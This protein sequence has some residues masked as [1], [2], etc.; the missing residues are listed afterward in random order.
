[1][2]VSHYK[3]TPPGIMA[4][5]DLFAKNKLSYLLF[6][7]D[8]IFEGQN[9]NLDILFETNEDYAHAGKILQEQGF[10]IRLSEKVERYKTM[11]TGFVRQEMY[12]IHLHREIAWHGMIA[13]DKK[14]V[15]QHKKIITPHIII[16]GLEDS[17]LIHAAHVLFENFRITEKE[18]VYL[19]K[20]GCADKAYLRDQISKHHWKDGFQKVIQNKVSI[21]AIAATWS[22]KLLNEPGTMVY[23]GIKLMKKIKRTLS[24]KRQGVL[25]ALIGV[26]G[27]GKTTLAKKTLEQYQPY[28][29]HLGYPEHYYYFGWNPEFFLTRFFSTILRRTKK[30]LFSAVALA[31]T[32]KKCSLFQELLFLFL[33]GE[34]YYRYI[35][36][37]KPK[38][39]RK[40]LIICDRYFYD[41]YGQYPYAP[42]SLI[43]KKLLKIFPRP[44][45]TFLL[46]ASIDNI[47][48]RGKEDK[49]TSANSPIVRTVLPRPYLQKQVENY[50]NLEQII[51]LSKINTEQE[52]SFCAA[53]IIEKSW[54]KVV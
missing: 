45:Y 24:C 9:K 6:K 27:T 1:M 26:N 31:S 13:L 50:S 52:L 33:F 41:M 49:G 7:C 53:Y 54:R 10:V 20:I 43:L 25:I 2:N 3:Q 51:P 40:G 30:N 23:L 44:N 17:I 8:H 47:K 34:F 28:M 12:S 42:R 18:K 5:L 29:K 32:A 19:S 36:H 46:T 16:P 37:I 11:Y 14:E 21:A 15:F 39:Q 38:L 35:V 22:K 4:V 48:R